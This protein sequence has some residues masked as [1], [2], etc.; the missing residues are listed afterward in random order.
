MDPNI[1]VKVYVNSMEEKLE[2]WAV[3]LAQKLKETLGIYVIF[4]RT[5]LGDCIYIRV[6]D[7]GRYNYDLFCWKWFSSYNE[8]FVMFDLERRASYPAKDWDTVL[9]LLVEL[10]RLVIYRLINGKTPFVE[11]I[12][13]PSQKLEYW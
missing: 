9:N 5:D 6:K 1:E 2:P 4:E 7:N 13:T 3:Q 12:H 10:V 8:L 11:G